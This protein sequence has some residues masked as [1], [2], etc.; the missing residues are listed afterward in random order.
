MRPLGVDSIEFDDEGTARDSL[1]PI[2]PGTYELR[3][4]GTISDS[5]RAVLNVR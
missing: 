5:Q 1:V 4:P 2:R 3:V